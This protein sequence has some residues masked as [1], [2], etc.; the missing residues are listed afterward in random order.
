MS[1][2]TTQ[3][4]P[5][6]GPI[7]VELVDSKFFTRWPCT[8]CGGCTEKVGVL[9]EAA[10]DEIRVCETCLQWGVIDTELEIHAEKLEERADWL[11]SLKGRLQVP[12]FTE[13]QA[14]MNEV[15]QEYKQMYP[16]WSDGPQL[17]TD[18]ESLPF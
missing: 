17:V 1:E 18:H 8:V 5:D 16:E 6:D 15:E 10:E 13:W 12:T 9:A 11:R 2:T 7:N 14:R 4:R 3:F